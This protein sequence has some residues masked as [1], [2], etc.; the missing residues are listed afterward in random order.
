MK[1]SNNVKSLGGSLELKPLEQSKCSM[2]QT[3]G[4][5]DVGIAIKVIKMHRICL[6]AGTQAQLAITG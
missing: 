3:L 4:Y 1:V 5:K 6:G 2:L